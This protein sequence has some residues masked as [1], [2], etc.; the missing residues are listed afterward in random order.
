MTETGLVISTEGGLAVVET[1]RGDM[2]AKCGAC[3]VTGGERA[4]R[5]SLANAVGARPGDRVTLELAEGAFLSAAL[6]MY[7][8]PLAAFLAGLIGG[9]ALWGALG[10][11]GGD[12][13]AFAAGGAATLIAYRAI[14]SREKRWRGEKYNPKITGI[15]KAR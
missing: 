5:V 3:G 10:L 12:F 6:V 9:W 7:G 4:S 8:A 1:A 14:A 11:P 13:A 15:V 2:C